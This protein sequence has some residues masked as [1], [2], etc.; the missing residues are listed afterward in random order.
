M[1]NTN[2]IVQT[3]MRDLNITK[4]T[5]L[6]GSISVK[7]AK[8]KLNNIPNGLDFFMSKNEAL[9]KHYNLNYE[10]IQ[11]NQISIFDLIVDTY[12]YSTEKDVLLDVGSLKDY[13]FFSSR[14]CDF[15]RGESLL[16]P[17]VEY[18]YNK[19]EDKENFLNLNGSEELRYK[20][21]VF[22][23]FK[24]MV[25][26][27]CCNHRLYGMVKAFNILKNSK[28]LVHEL[29]TLKVTLKKASIYDYITQDLLVK[30]SNGEF[31]ITQLEDSKIEIKLNDVTY[32]WFIKDSTQSCLENKLIVDFIENINRCNFISK[33]LNIRNIF[34]LENI[35]G[36]IEVTYHTKKKNIKLVLNPNNMENMYNLDMFASYSY[37]KLIKFSIDYMFGLY[38]IGNNEFHIKN[39]KNRE[40][41]TY[42]LIKA[43]KSLI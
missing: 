17:L 6:S 25:G 9:C 16:V 42:Y 40:E 13:Y 35:K 3:I 37:M 4:R 21:Y 2:A 32:Y 24:I 8:E 7:L 11:K 5:L 12:S 29:N 36:D 14:G 28:V 43:L 18:Y 26:S 27:G 33:K 19:L 10:N 31:I 22:D 39:I 23:D 30:L 34:F 38:M 15:G 20:I 41:R 1:N